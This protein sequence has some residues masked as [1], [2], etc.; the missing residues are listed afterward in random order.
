[1]VAVLTLWNLGWWAVFGLA[2]RPW[3]PGGW[4]MI[5]VVALVSLAV[6]L[7][8]FQRAMAGRL[9]PGAAVRLLVFR[10]F[11]Y[12]Q[13]LLPLL[14]I[15]ALLGAAAGWAFGAAAIAG[16]YTVAGTAAVLAVVGVAGWVGSRLLVTRTLTASLPDLPA[17]LEGLRIVQVSDLHVGP[18]TSRRYLARVR[19]AM[20]GAAPDLIVFTGDQVD[21]FP[22]DTE[23][24][25]RAFGGLEA[26]LGVFAVAGN[27][28]VYARWGAVRAGLED[29]GQRV[30]V[31][32]A[33]ELRRDGSSLWLAGTGD[34]AGRGF[35]EGRGGEAAPDLEATLAA[36]PSSAFVVALAH[37]PVLWP[38]LAQRGVALTLSGHTH[39]GQ[40]SVPHLSWSL[41]SVFLEHAMGGYEATGSLLYINPGTNC[42]GLPFRLGALPEVTVIELRRGERAALTG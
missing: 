30:L 34:P 26:P 37:N 38:A 1:M 29:A 2:L 10:P 16:R 4:A 12:L 17:G 19:A 33:V 5:G 8:V 32:E 24:F 28:D 23:P 39:H 25:A 41:A 15:A 27:H 21:D 3:I 22:R 6:P 14:G 35:V 20:V 40:L 9:Y 11:W 7:G 42:W 18:H 36:V 13:L 31:N